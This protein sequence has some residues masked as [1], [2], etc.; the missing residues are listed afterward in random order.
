[1]LK[2][3]EKQGFSITETGDPSQLT[4]EK[5]TALLAK[6]GEFPKVVANAAEK[7]TPHNV[8]QYVYD[9]A[10]HLHSFYN[11]EKVLDKENKPR[12]EA[13]IALMKAVQ[14]TLKNALTLIGVTAPE[15][16]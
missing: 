5:E 9:L 1:M 13:R 4:T 15:Q 11:A 6:L 14:I 3:A 10:A 2:Q 12:T 16:M 7:Y 8:T